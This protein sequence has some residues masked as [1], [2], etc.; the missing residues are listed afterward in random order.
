MPFVAK[1]V[2][3]AHS[4]LVVSLISLAKFIPILFIAFVG[5]ALADAVDRRAMVRLTEVSL[6]IVSAGLLVNA[7]LP[8]PQLWALFL[9]ASLAAGF[10]ALQRPSLDALVPRVVPREQLASAGALEILG[11]SL[12]HVA[13]PALAGLLIAAAGLPITYGVDIATFAVSLFMLSLMRAVPPPLGAERP[14]LSSIRAGLR[15]A[16]GRQD[17]LGTYAVDMGAMLFGMPT[18]LFPQIATQF[19]GPAVLGLLYAA[20]SVGGLLTAASS[21]WVSHVHRHGRA[22]AVAA[23]VWGLAIVGFG[24]APW[25]WAALLALAVAGAGDMV[26]GVFRQTIWNQT[27]PDALRGRLAGVEMISYTSGPTL[28]NVEAGIVAALAGVRASV[29]SGGVLCVLATVALSAALPKF[30]RYSAAPPAAD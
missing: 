7:A 6:C 10:G 13:G 3:A 29:V 26:S 14:S 21:G 20:P 15:Y 1:R 22:I 9:A 30:W 4:S 19:G 2:K 28:G 17:L 18:A 25:L 11:G 27:I 16:L 12:A 5:G 23:A 24:L 8:Q